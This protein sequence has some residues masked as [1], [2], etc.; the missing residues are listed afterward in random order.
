ME[1]GWKAVEGVLQQ[2]TA[3]D[4]ITA[5]SHKIADAFLDSVGA[6]AG[7]LYSSGFKG[8][9]DAVSDRLN[10]DAAA[11]VAWVAGMSAGIQS[12]GG[13]T[14]GQKTMVDA[15]A[16]AAEAARQMLSSGGSAGACVTAAADAAA[17]GAEATAALIS[18]MG[19]SKKLGERARGHVDPGAA[20]AAMLLRAWAEV[21]S[22]T[23]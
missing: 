23:P 4:T 8:A 13:A 21:L 10:M 19:R 17:E 18:Q 9:G 20:S 16:P 7:P 14:V 12:R 6:S 3:T 15:W 11:T 22:D 5:L 2:S 1:I